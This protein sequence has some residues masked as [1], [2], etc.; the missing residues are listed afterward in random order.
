[1]KTHPFLYLLLF[2]LFSNFVLGQT[3]TVA[4]VILDDYDNPVENVNVSYLTT[5]TTTNASG[6]Y[7][8]EVPAN[9]KIT[10]VF[11]HVSLNKGSATLTLVPNEKYEL[12]FKMTS[13]AQKLED[14]VILNDK[15]RLQGIISLTPEVIVIELVVVAPKSVTCCKS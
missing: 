9:K 1:M 13:N 8:L 10:I 3:A 7:T 5:T 14:V 4:G 2:L 15:K 6:F 11:T 12:Y